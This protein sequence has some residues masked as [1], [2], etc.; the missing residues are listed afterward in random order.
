MSEILRTKAIDDGRSSFNIIHEDQ[1]DFLFINQYSAECPL[2]PPGP[3]RQLIGS[4]V[5]RNIHRNKRKRSVLFLTPSWKRHLQDQLSR[6]NLYTKSLQGHLL[7]P[8]YSA[9]DSFSPESLPKEMEHNSEY[10]EFYRS[11]DVQ[12]Q[13]GKSHNLDSKILP[14]P[15]NESHPEERRGNRAK[16]LKKLDRLNNI[17]ATVPGLQQEGHEYQSNKKQA[18]SAMVQKDVVTRLR[19]SSHRQLSMPSRVPLISAVM[20]GNSDPFSASAIKITATAHELLQLSYHWQLFLTYPV[21]ASE[22]YNDYVFEKQQKYIRDMLGDPAALHCLLASGYFISSQVGLRNLYALRHK[23]LA[24][25]LVRQCLAAHPI[26]DVSHAVYHLLAIEL[27]CGDYKAAFQHHEALRLII[28]ADDHGSLTH[29]LPHLW[30]SDV[31]LAYHL[32]RR[33]II[34]IDTWD[35]PTSAKKYE[36]AYLGICQYNENSISRALEMYEA[37]SS[38]IEVITA[39]HKTSVLKRLSFDIPDSQSQEA[40]IQ[41]LHLR[42]ASLDGRLINYLIDQID[43]SS[44]EQSNITSLTLTQALNSSIILAAMCYLHL[45]CSAVKYGGGRLT[46]HTMFEPIL[47]HLF[48]LALI[49]Q[50]SISHDLKIWLVFMCA[51]NNTLIPQAKSSQWSLVTLAT[52]QGS[53]GYGNCDDLHQ[54]LRKFLYHERMEKL[55]ASPSINRL[56]IYPRQEVVEFIG[57]K[58]WAS[59]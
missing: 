38:L 2:Q 15:G 56:I 46:I 52:L 28:A 31:W 50:V 51:I 11:K 19:A 58:F 12:E 45:E 26:T 29:M 47:Q 30:I 18:Y 24:I 40:L 48:Q 44:N 27:F 4:H 14:K 1:E 57:N 37:D 59:T 32:R 9:V 21:W 17:P 16:L 3:D 42:A 43:I 49:D 36:D 55:L 25:H 39:I 13:G 23:T 53:L 22:L 7:K 34:E 41:W 33:T 5:Q 6:G 8:Y 10:S 35:E 20:Q 54:V